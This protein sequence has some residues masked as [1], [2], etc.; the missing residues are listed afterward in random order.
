MGFLP[1]DWISLLITVSGVRQQSWLLVGPGILGMMHTAFSAG[2]CRS[3]LLSG[4]HLMYCS[5]IDCWKSI[6]RNGALK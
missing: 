5:L 2:T 3:S 6:K 4:L 1:R